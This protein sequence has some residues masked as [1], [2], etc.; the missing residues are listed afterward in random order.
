MTNN[1]AEISSLQSKVITCLR[2][3]LAVGVVMIHASISALTIDGQNITDSLSLPGYIFIEGFFNSI[4][5][6]TAVPLFFFISGF[7]FFNKDPDFSI[8]IYRA[9]I[10]KRIK[11]LLIPYLLWNLA[12]LILL[13]IVQSILPELT[14]G[15]NKLIIDYS[16]KDW[17]LSF[18]DVSYRTG[19]LTLPI[20][21]PL[22]FIRDLM[23]V[24]VLSPIVYFLVRYLK[25]FAI[26][27][28]AF[29]W[30]SGY[31]GFFV[32]LSMPAILFFSIGTW[33]GINEY[34]FVHKSK[35]TFLTIS[36]IL[37]AIVGVILQTNMIQKPAYSYLNKLELLFGC[38]LII[39]T[40]AYFIEKGTWRPNSFLAGSS[41]FIF[42]YHGPAITFIERT[43]WKLFTPES[44]ISVTLFYI[45]S[46][47]FT[48][49]LGLLLYWA[50]RK[51]S[52]SFAG[53]ITG[54][55]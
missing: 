3:P 46:I 54:G 21:G 45:I 31:P 19:G 9:K 29:I 32:G 23:V 53:F 12:I 52:P 43:L 55:R 35:L 22:W 49:G 18:W 33:F 8:K 7:L 27:L 6:Q 39:Q 41:F 20:N 30:L 4:F 42:A 17:A 11:T 24:M 48:V 16:L 1:S 28:L 51:I 26:I 47:I 25:I 37:Y 50:I 34:P 5:T 15:R 44:D 13:L 36:L 38:I 2:F 10:K 14:S 40:T